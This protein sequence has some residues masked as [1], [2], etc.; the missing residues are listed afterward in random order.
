MRVFKKEKNKK[1]KNYSLRERPQGTRLSLRSIEKQRKTKAT[2]AT[3]LKSS[4]Q[5]FRLD[6]LNLKPKTF[7][8]VQEA[9][10]IA[11]GNYKNIKASL[12]NLHK[13]IAFV[14]PSAFDKYSYTIKDN[15]SQIYN[16]IEIEFLKL[17]LP[18]SDYILF[19][20]NGEYPIFIEYIEL[21]CEQ[22]P[23]G[24]PI[25]ILNDIKDHDIQLYELMVVIF[26]FLIQQS[27]VQFASIKGHYIGE[28]IEDNLLERCSEEYCDNN[29]DEMLEAEEIKQALK[30]HSTNGKI[31]SF[32]DLLWKAKTIQSNQIIDAIKGYYKC[33]K[34]NFLIVDIEQWALEM[35]K[36]FD[37]NPKQYVCDYDFFR[38]DPGLMDGEPIWFSDTMLCYWNANDIVM[39]ETNN[40]L[41]SMGNE[42]GIC[43]PTWYRKWNGVSVQKPIK[44]K[45]W[46]VQVYKLF[47]DFKYKLMPK[48][49]KK[50]EFER[51]KYY[52]D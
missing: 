25:G 19:D 8:E 12:F 7:L 22:H 26:Q 4:I 9:L 52:Y 30:D 24:L 41:N 11:Q 48:I 15:L 27:G 16:D 29:A 36:L 28:M 38:H 34:V 14:N 47:D 5:E 43:S 13:I 42:V 32:A 49:I 39:T 6:S 37:S 17:K 45:K 51:S 3:P 31:K 21:D 10:G 2:H 33:K 40:W 44:N 20:E 35:I 23:V 46:P 18:E 50:Y 1:V